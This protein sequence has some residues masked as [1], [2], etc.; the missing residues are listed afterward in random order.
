EPAPDREGERLPPRIGPALEQRLPRGRPE[1]SVV[2]PATRCRDRLS[3]LR[4]EAWMR[5][6]LVEQRDPRLQRPRPI[7]AEASRPDPVAQERLANEPGTCSVQDHPD[8]R[9]P[10]RAVAKRL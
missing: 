7:R 2:R 5:Q 4:R 3:L 8:P 1:R 6:D 9:V 10:V